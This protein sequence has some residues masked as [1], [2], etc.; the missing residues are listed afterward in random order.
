[1]RKSVRFFSLLSLLMGTVLF[2]TTLK[3]ADRLWEKRNGFSGETAKQ[4][5]L[6]YKEVVD[7]NPQSYE[8]YWKYSRALNWYGMNMATDNK[9]K[10]EIF[11]KAKDAAMLSTQ[12]NP[13]GVEGHVWLGVN[14]GT[15]GEANGILNSLKAVPE[16]ERNMNEVLTT[17]PDY[18][19]AIAYRVLGRLYFK[20]PGAPLSIGDKEKSEQYLRRAYQ[21]APLNKKNALYLAEILVAKKNNKEALQVLDEALSKPVRPSN[22][23]EEDADLKEMKALKARI[24][25]K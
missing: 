25:E 24:S 3:D 21:I 2:A 14:W 11:L 23:I 20:A 10:K 13:N 5:Y 7:A 15:W 18:D 17:N 22:R 8:A 1:M 12:I 4:V 19:E 6:K 9:T 16:I